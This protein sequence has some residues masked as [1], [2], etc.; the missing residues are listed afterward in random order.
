VAGLADL[1]LN[2]EPKGL[3][4]VQ[5]VM[6]EEAARRAHSGAEVHLLNAVL[7]A[8]RGK[9]KHSLA[10]FQAALAAGVPTLMID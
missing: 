1:G 8:W 7:S 4:L 2:E 5:A 9:R 3:G 6:E 10:S